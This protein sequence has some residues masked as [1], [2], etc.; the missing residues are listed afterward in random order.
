MRASRTYAV[1][2]L[3]CHGEE[4]HAICKTGGWLGVFLGED[5]I[6]SGANPPSPQT[7]ES[8]AEENR[9]LREENESLKRRLGDK[10]STAIKEP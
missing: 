4:H 2:Y 6:V 7:V 1:H 5:R 9:R 8:L 3:D 10:D